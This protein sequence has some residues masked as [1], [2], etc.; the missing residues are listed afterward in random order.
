L[1]QSEAYNFTRFQRKLLPQ[2]L[3]TQEQGHQHELNNDRVKK[4]KLPHK[5]ALAQETIF[6]ISSRRILVERDISRQNPTSLQSAKKLPTPKQIHNHTTNFIF[7][8][9]IPKQKR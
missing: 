6:P 5:E 1:E 7:S 9:I 4:N 8:K 2:T 3:A